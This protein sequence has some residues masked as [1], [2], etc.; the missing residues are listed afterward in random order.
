[1]AIRKGKGVDKTKAVKKVKEQKASAAETQKPEETKPEVNPTP[2]PEEIKPEAP[3]APETPKPEELAALAAEEPSAEEL[4]EEPVVE[5]TL[6]ERCIRESGFLKTDIYARYD[7][8]T[9]AMVVS[10][11][12]KKFRIEQ[13]D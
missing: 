10:T 8:G 4:D 13:E 2:D 11:S 3:A 7:G 6:M 12:G 1:M 5:E 9:W